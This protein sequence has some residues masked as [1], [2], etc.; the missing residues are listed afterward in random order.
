MELGRLD[1]RSALIE[2]GYL[3][4]PGA[5]FQMNEFTTLAR[6]MCI[7]FLRGHSALSCSGFRA[8]HGSLDSIGFLDQFG[9][10]QRCSFSF[11]NMAR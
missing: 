9:T 6:F 4:C 3:S 1:F 11:A 7:G 8:V 2:A 10:L 5:L